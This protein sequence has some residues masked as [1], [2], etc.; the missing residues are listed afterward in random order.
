VA[1]PTHSWASL[2]WWTRVSIAACQEEICLAAVED[3]DG[4]Q[5]VVRLEID[6]ARTIARYLAMR[7]RSLFDQDLASGSAWG[8]DL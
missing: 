4:E 5:L 3:D 1:P 7:A 6:E 8:S 2:S